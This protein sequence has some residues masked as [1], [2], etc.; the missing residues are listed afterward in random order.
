MPAKP[1]ATG[2]GRKGKAGKAAD[3]KS[4][5]PAG[6]SPPARSQSVSS[7]VSESVASARTGRGGR[8]VKNESSG[9]PTANSADA[10]EAD[11]ASTTP[12]VKRAQSVK[13]KRAE[14]QA[15]DVA[16]VTPTAT[17]VAPMAMQALD[18]VIAYRN[19][20]KM[21]QP[22]MNIISSHKHASIFAEPVRERQ[23]E[24]YRDIIKR[25]QDLKSIRAAI[26]AG[27]RAVAAA[28]DAQQTS[29]GSTISSANSNAV[30]LPVS[31]ALIPP[32][33]IV[34]AAQLEQEVMRMFANA[35]MFNPG[36][37]EIV[38]DSREMFES[39]EQALQQWRDVERMGE[40]E[41]PPRDDDEA[42]PGSS[43]RR[44]A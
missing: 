35:V 32:K 1:V 25:P 10:A 26:A 8:R 29:P 27:S 9:G 33:G 34:N 22:V 7:Q 13:R 42:V 38:Q 21:A 44:R 31:E 17:V 39:V 19:F 30:T 43:K 11:P 18:T 28:V 4:V 16:A 41:E 40:T 23:A 2:R 3:R 37:D 5:A 36:D 12:Q 15:E 24:G 6:R 20:G 14:S